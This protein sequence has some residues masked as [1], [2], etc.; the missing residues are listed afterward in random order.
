MNRL[1]GE[2][3]SLL[4]APWVALCAIYPPQT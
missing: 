4:A 3:A 1:G 2:E